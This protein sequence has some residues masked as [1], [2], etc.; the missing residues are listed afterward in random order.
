M[1]LPWVSY[2][3]YKVLDAHLRVC[4]KDFDPLGGDEQI[5]LGEGLRFSVGTLLQGKNT[6]TIWW[7]SIPNQTL[8]LKV[9]VVV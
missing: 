6:K 3:W 9:S 4:I 2:K 1:V 7:T 8:Q 5:H